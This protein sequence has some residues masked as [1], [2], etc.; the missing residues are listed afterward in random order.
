MSW[1]V[2]VRRDGVDVVTLGST[3]LCGR[4]LDEADIATIRRAADH[5]LAFVGSP[6][7][8]QFITLAR[9]DARALAYVLARAIREDHEASEADRRE[10]RA[11]IEKLGGLEQ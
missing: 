8:V 7:D 3:L 11:M 6:A 2:T 5:L 9:T 10:A 1:E 4:A